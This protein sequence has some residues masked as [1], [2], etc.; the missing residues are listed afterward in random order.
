MQFLNLARDRPT[1]AFTLLEEALDANPLSSRLRVDYASVLVSEGYFDE[2]RMMAKSAAGMEPIGFDLA[3]TWIIRATADLAEGREEEARTNVHRANYAY[4]RNIYATPSAIVIL[5]VLGDRD[6]AARLYREFVSEVPEFSFEN[7]LTKYY[8][9]SIGPVITS[10][11]RTDVE[12][13][14]DVSAIVGRLASQ[15]ATPAN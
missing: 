4:A 7:P 8:L 11:H 13:P 9:K 3:T 14:P 15:A 2:A 1:E 12:F 6:D 5:Y 10:R